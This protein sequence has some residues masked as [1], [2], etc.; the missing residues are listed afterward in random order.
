MKKYPYS[1]G[2]KV[3]GTSKE[4]A[5]KVSPKDKKYRDKCLELLRLQALTADEIAKIL[6]VPYGSIRP[7]VSQLHTAGV[8]KD[9]GERRKNDFGNPMNVWSAL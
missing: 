2:Y 7:R 5:E 9:T 3:K 6:K 8:I 1:P 4:A